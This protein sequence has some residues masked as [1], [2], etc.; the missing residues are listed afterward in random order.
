MTKTLAR[1]ARSLAL[2]VAVAAV[3]A[4]VTVS[5][6]IWAGPPADATFIGVKKCKTCHYKETKRWKKMKHAEAWEKLPDADKKKPLCIKCH[7][8][9][10][11]KPG[12][13]VSEEKTP[14]MAAVQC[15][16]CHGAGSAHVKAA[17]DDAAEDKIKS[18]INK[19]PA[20]TCVK[21]HDPHKKHADYEE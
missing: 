21:C 11:G 15:E 6:S 12:G 16:S 19:V 18:L 4:V 9:G 8:T 5:S 17:T 2:F 3:A 7:V 10:Y 13:F 1:N 14:H 20:N